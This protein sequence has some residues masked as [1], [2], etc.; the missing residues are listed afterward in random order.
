MN[1][2]AR[3]TALLAGLLLIG[4]GGTLHGDQNF[5][6]SMYLRGAIGESM[7]TES[8]P[9][10]SSAP[11][12]LWSE[13]GSLA[14]GYQSAWLVGLELGL[15]IDANDQYNTVVQGSPTGFTVPTDVIYIMPCLRLATDGLYGRPSFHTLGFQLGSSSPPSSATE[16]EDSALTPSLTTYGLCY[17][18]EQML[19][20][21]FS[22]GL[23]FTYRWAT[24]QPVVFAD[25]GY[26]AT[27]IPVNLNLSG[28]SIKITLS[29]WPGRPFITDADRAEDEARLQTRRDR[30]RRRYGNGD[31]DV[32]PEVEAVAAKNLV[33]QGDSLMARQSYE[34]ASVFYLRA[35]RIDAESRWAWQG[36]GNARF[37]LGRKAAA[38]VA[39]REAY[40]FSQDD[41][42]L[43]ALIDKLSN[44]VKDGQPDLPDSGP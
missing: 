18:V 33:A 21:R 26:S 22:L 28:P 25:N 20:Q 43:K 41:P 42:K 31:L 6:N 16:T 24:Y 17:R 32:D 8:N 9:D 19:G 11:M 12:N 3:I 30:R 15:N 34:E 39:Y 40:G 35:I 7:I 5:G 14:V 27:E 38:L 37:Y 44:E 2:E 4:A 36:L 13:S 10:G 1:S 29:F 23:D